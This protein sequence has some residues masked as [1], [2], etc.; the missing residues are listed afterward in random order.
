MSINLFEYDI[1]GILYKNYQRGD[2]G[3]NFWKKFMQPPNTTI[4]LFINEDKI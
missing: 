1:F 4:F 3:T 2:Q